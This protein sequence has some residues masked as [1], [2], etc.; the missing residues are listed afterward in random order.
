MP[1]TLASF[2][3]VNLR[4]GSQLDADQDAA[5]DHRCEQRMTNA[6]RRRGPDGEQDAEID[7]VTVVEARPYRLA[8]NRSMMT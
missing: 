7:R 2:D 4:P 6:H 5:G 3:S 8:T 1:Y